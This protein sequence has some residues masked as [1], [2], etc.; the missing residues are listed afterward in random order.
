M[1]SIPIE[2]DIA[3]PKS[4]K[5]EDHSRRSDG[6]QDSYECPSHNSVYFCELKKE[7]TSLSAAPI[8]QTDELYNSLLEF[9]RRKD[10]LESGYLER[11][12]HKI[13]KSLSELNQIREEK[14]FGPLRINYLEKFHIYFSLKSKT[15]I[16]ENELKH[17]KNWN[18]ELELVDCIDDNMHKFIIKFIK[19]LSMLIVKWKLFDIGKYMFRYKGRSLTV[20][21]LNM[22]KINK[23][24]MDADVFWMCFAIKHLPF[25]DFIEKN[26]VNY[27]DLLI[28]SINRLFEFF[29]GNELD[30]T[31]TSLDIIPKWKILLG[32]KTSPA[33][34]RLYNLI[35]AL[36]KAYR[37][38]EKHMIQEILKVVI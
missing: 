38:F 17:I 26:L 33:V 29:E 21:V 8:F 30:L 25:L 22:T 5:I 13:S 35:D 15:S 4:D 14:G 19:A 37:A 32:K 6:G 9:L 3:S 36:E 23:Q 34:M 28:F 10:F 24:C 20:K 2:N 12:F 18:E 16:S 27:A 11:K 1:T 7:R 31:N